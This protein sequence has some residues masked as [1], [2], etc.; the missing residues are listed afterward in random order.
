MFAGVTA[1]RLPTKDSS[2]QALQG[3][4]C[5]DVLSISEVRL[6]FLDTLRHLWT[7]LQA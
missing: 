2:L 4:N 7:Q 5:S 1:F 3:L 6:L